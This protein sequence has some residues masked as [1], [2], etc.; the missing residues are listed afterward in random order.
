MDKIFE[1]HLKGIY[2]DEFIK[3]CTEVSSDFFTAIFDCFYSYIPCVQNFLL[4]KAHYKFF[5]LQ[6]RNI[7]QA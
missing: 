2:F 3:I 6:H 1:H 5:I 4:L 7:E